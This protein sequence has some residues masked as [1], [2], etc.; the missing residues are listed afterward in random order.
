MNMDMIEREID[1]NRHALILE[2]ER[3]G[4]RERMREESE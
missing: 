1:M 4:E 3:E 2:R